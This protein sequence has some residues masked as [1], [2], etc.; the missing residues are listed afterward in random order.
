ML[1]HTK[2][3]V[4]EIKKTIIRSNSPRALK[5]YSRTGR[6]RGA[7]DKKSNENEHGKTCT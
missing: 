6:I 3:T 2:F 5:F 7:Q 1:V 4:L